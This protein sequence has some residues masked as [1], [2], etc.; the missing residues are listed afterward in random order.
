M[1]LDEL[2]NAMKSDIKSGNFTL[3]AVFDRHIK[4]IL[5]LKEQGYTYNSIFNSLAL[6]IDQRHFDNLRFRS[7]KKIEKLRPVNKVAAQGAI[8]VKV[9]TPSLP[10]DDN[11]DE[12]SVEEWEMETGLS[13]SPRLVEKLIRNKFTPS[14]LKE[15]NLTTPSKINN[16]LTTHENT[17]KYK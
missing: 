7:N 3:Q 16:Y 10:Y 8:A 14:K 2:S 6:G 4:T 12:S 11:F 5:E 9:N 15:L 13:L 1:D 17:N